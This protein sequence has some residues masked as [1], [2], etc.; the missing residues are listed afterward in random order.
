MDGQGYGFFDL[1][2]VQYSML[3]LSGKHISWKKCPQLNAI[4]FIFN[5]SEIKKELK[6]KFHYLFGGIFSNAPLNL[7]Q[8]TF[9]DNILPT[10]ATNII[11]RN[12]NSL[13]LASNV[14]IMQVEIVAHQNIV[15]AIL[16]RYLQT[17]IAQH[18]DQ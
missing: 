14:T 11:T 1:Q 4:I 18:F 13:L 6:R 10:Q 8:F 15:T 9:D 7:I 16:N 2:T 17:Q 3:Y 5:G 12:V